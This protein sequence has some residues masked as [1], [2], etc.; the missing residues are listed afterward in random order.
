MAPIGVMVS[1]VAPFWVIDE[2]NPSKRMISLQIEEYFTIQTL[3]AMLI[4]L[5]VLFFFKDNPKNG[6]VD[7]TKDGL[8]VP[9][10]TQIKNLF[11]DVPYICLFLAFGITN[12]VLAGITA[13][14]SPTIAIWE[15]FEVIFI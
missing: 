12:G 8:R 15:K 9:F 3:A 2:S 5:T 13:T 7:Y 14:L 4:F 10:G 6:G 1:S 11:S